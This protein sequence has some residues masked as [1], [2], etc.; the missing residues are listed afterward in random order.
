MKAPPLHRA[1]NDYLATR[2]SLGFKLDRAHKLLPGFAD[3]LAETGKFFVTTKAALAWATLPQSARSNWWAMRLVLVR[4]FAK[5]MQTLDPRTEVPPLEL[6]PYRRVRPQPYVYTAGDVVALLEAAHA[7][8]LPLMAATYTTVIGLLSISGM[9]IGEAIA[10][11][12]DDVD[13]HRGILTI[14]KSKFGKTREVPVHATTV[15][16]LARYHKK[17]EYRWPS[18]KEP[19]FFVSTAGTRLLYQNVNIK[20]RELVCTAGLDT[21]QPRPRIHDLRHTFAI[22]TVVAWYRDGEDVE[23]RL[24]QLSTYLGHI[25]PSSTYWYLSAVPELLEAATA[26]L[27]RALEKVR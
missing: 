7:L 15:D 9:R 20:F 10:L 18:C 21:R 4:G 23:A 11:N 1:L 17:R 24:P 16:A 3:Y 5:Y 26:R 12:N 25:S 13:L 8:P 14:R 2:R 6:L 22:R 27:E 19:S